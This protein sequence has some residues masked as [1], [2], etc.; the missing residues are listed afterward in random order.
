MIQI[1]LV[2]ACTRVV[3]SMIEKKSLVV[4]G[5]VFVLALVLTPLLADVIDYGT[6]GIS[7]GILGLWMRTRSLLFATRA[8]A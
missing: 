6:L 2:I 5:L 7:F 4:Q 8:S 1:L 3:L